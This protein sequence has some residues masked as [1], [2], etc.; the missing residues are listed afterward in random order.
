MSEVS[1]RSID[2]L[3]FFVFNQSIYLIKGFFT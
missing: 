1:T 2:N 3:H